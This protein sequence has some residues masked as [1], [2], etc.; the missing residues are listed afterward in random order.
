MRKSLWTLAVVFITACSSTPSEEASNDTETTQSLGYHFAPQ[1]GKKN[2]TISLFKSGETYHLFYAT[3]SDEWG[4]AESPNLIHWKTVSTLNLPN[5]S[6][7]DVVAD[8]YNTS[9]LSPAGNEV[10]VA[11]FTN[12]G[13]I[14]FQH[15]AD[16]TSW[17]STPIDLP[18]GVQG[19]PKITWYDPTEL[20][21]M[22]VVNSTTIKLLSSK[23]LQVWKEESELSLNDPINSAELF[24]IANNWALLL[25]GETLQYQTGTFNGAEFTSESA[26]ELIDQRGTLESAVIFDDSESSFLIGQ[27]DKNILTSPMRIMTSNEKL[28]FFPIDGFK[29]QITGKRRGK[30]DLLRGDRSS[31]FHFPIESV[32]ENVELL[33]SNDEVELLRI[34]LD[35]SQNK[36]VVDRTSAVKNQSGSSDE[37]PLNVSGNQIE[38]DI[39]IDYQQIELFINGGTHFFSIDVTPNKIYD[40]ID[41]KVDGETTNPRTILYTISP[42]PV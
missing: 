40:K 28:S 1:H 34:N 11:A 5:D 7:G 26:M 9:G 8:I 38:V 35:L 27:S 14:E 21:I 13:V 24:S 12:N 42:D 19:T 41:V 31:W 25:N 36:L 17:T 37:Y 39:I 23:D 32:N 22:T 29:K 33:L 3:G 4:H 6:N 2:K 10:W 15:T 20:W 30:L 18:E 16:Q